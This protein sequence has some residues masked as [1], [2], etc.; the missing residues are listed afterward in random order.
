[1]LRENIVLFDS[2][3]AITK[4][5]NLP[6]KASFAT[7]QHRHSEALTGADGF[8]GLSVGNILTQK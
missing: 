2:K 1:M 4:R 7:A 3:G 8:I 5:E 6:G